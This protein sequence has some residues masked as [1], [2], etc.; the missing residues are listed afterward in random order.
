LYAVLLFIGP[1]NGSSSATNV[2]AVVLLLAVVVLG[3]VVSRP[4][5]LLRLFTQSPMRRM[6]I[7][8]ADVFFVLFFF[9]FP[10]A[11]KYETTVLGNG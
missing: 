10:S 11:K 9:V 8:F 5:G 6:R 7:C 4:S 3:V 2:V 1:G